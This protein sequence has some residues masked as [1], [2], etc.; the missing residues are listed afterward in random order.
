MNAITVPQIDAERPE[1]FVS[2]G[3]FS[4]RRIIATF[5]SF[6]RGIDLVSTKQVH[7]E[8]TPEQRANVLSL[9]S[10]GHSLRA[11]AR[12][13]SVNVSTVNLWKQASK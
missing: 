10:A 2:C 7:A 9:L 4:N 6:M 11:V 1:S 5:N 8:Y 12:M 3:F 13:T